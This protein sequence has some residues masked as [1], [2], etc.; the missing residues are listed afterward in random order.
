MSAASISDRALG[1]RRVLFD[2]LAD[3]RHWAAAA[4][5]RRDLRD[6]IESLDRVGELDGVLGECSLSRSDI[7]TIVTADPEASRRLERMLERLDLTDRLRT[8]ERS[9][10]RDIEVVCLRCQ[11][12]GQ[13]EHW[14]QGD[15]K[16]GMEDFCPNAETF[17]ALRGAQRSDA[18]E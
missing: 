11:A 1:F 18:I 17:K 14:L 12:T 9:W 2:F 6:E 15:Q 16:G 4:K 5:S 13:C 3:A 8:S 7:E 10:S